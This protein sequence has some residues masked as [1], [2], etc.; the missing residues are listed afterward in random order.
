[1]NLQAKAIKRVQFNFL[2]CTSYLTVQVVLQQF[3]DIL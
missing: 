1:M 2:V 3:A